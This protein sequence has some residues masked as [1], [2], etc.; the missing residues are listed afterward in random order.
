[1]SNDISA[2]NP[3]DDSAANVD[4]IQSFSKLRDV[5]LFI[6]LVAFSTLIN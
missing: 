1:M 6:V 3:T 4:F 2:D 5:S